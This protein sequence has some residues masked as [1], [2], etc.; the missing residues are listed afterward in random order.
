MLPDIAIITVLMLGVLFAP[1]PWR[2]VCAMLTVG[3][4]IASL[5]AL[6]RSF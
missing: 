4:C 1:N 5:I 3:C 2:R 6:L